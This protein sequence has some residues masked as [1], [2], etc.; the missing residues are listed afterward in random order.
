MQG[1]FEDTGDDDFSEVELSLSVRCT[2][3]ETMDVTSNDLVLDPNHPDVAPV[4]VLGSPRWIPA[5]ALQ[6]AATGREQDESCSQGVEQDAVT[7]APLGRAT[8]QC[9]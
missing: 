4:G 3:D 2:S 8:G 9:N 1:P 5:T 7:A 6:P